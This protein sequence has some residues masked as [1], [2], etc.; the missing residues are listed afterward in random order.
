MRGFGKD[1]KRSFIRDQIAE[2]KLEFVGL[3]ETMKTD[4]SHNE[5]H[6][7]SGGRNSLWNWSPLE[8]KLEAFWW[9]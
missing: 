9:G 7:L 2:K 4:F 3:L 1:F 6:N 8:V 5:L